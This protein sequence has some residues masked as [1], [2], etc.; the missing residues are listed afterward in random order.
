MDVTIIVA[1]TGQLVS[2]AVIIA[3]VAVSHG[4]TQGKIDA[5]SQRVDGLVDNV[6]RLFSK[7]NALAQAVAGLEANV[8]NY[9]GVAESLA[10][11]R[12]S[13]SG[14][15]AENASDHKAV[16]YDLDALGRR[17]E[18]IERQIA[19]LASGGAGRVV[20]FDGAN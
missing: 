2:L 13:F 18:N 5:L 19:H 3:A 12:E 16:R 9:S 15:R 20:A 6:E 10:G 8:S 7:S 4:R 17:T 1:L 14:L 11:L